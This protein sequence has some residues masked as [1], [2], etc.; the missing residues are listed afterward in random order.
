MPSNKNSTLWI[1]FLTI[2][3]DMLG[4][5]ILIPILPMLVA[6]SSSFSITPSGWTTAEGYIMLGW[7]MAVFPI[8]QFLF[9]PIL[10][11]L[12]D[13]FG[14]KKVL[15][16]SILGTALSYM[17][18][19]Y[20]LYAKNLPILFIAR[21]IDGIS[22]ANISTASAVI[23]DI[24]EPAKRARN[25]GLIGVSLG[26]GFILGP[27]LGGKLSDP[28]LINWFNVTT[29]FY[30]A[31]LMSFINLVLVMRKLPETLPVTIRQ[32]IDITKPFNN[33]KKAFLIPG[34]AN[35][36]FPIFLFNMG[37]T[38]F[39]TF[40]GVVLAVKYGFNQSMI[41]DF[42]A[43]TGLMMVLVQGGVVRRLSGKVADH[44]VLKFSM[45]ITGISLIIYCFIPT[46]HSHYLYLIP[47]F[48][49]LGASLTRA[50][51]QALLI[52][53]APENVRGEIMGINSS[54]FALAQI[55]PS[56]L[57]GYLAAQY[58]TLPTIF[59]GIIVIFGGIY[60]YKKFKNYIPQ[61]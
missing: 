27:F 38:F 10:G 39:T 47:P 19:A 36:M 2:F 25:F 58:T 61:K 29:P 44:K 4:L 17:L 1:I 57:A 12:S 37:F 9:T 46:T 34:I 8:F 22:G 41:G 24:S 6:P 49:A 16:V 54:N 42:F 35:I 30:F 56:I 11:Q 28:T 51:S 18:F 33:I 45:F 3:L 60:F 48:L 7:L 21:G 59:G 55:F 32:K 26:L 5:G 43:Y 14:R 40:F 50:F 13:R 52:N 53:I 20:G 23:G 31:A 15:L